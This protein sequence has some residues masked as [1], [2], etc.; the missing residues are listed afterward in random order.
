[1]KTTAASLIE[2]AASGGASGIG[3]AGGMSNIMK[4]F[5]LGG[6]ASSSVDNE[7]LILESNKVFTSMVDNLGLNTIYIE[8]DGIS[9][10][11]LYKDSPIIVEVPDSFFYRLKK[12]IQLK[13][14]LKDGKADI[15]LCSGFMGMKT[16]SEQNDVQLPAKIDYAEGDIYIMKSPS[17]SAN[18]NRNITVKLST[19][20]STVTALNKLVSIDF[21]DKLAD[22]IQIEIKYPNRELGEQ[23]VNT[24]MAEYN[25][26][27]RERRMTTS[28]EESAFLEKRI[29][30]LLPE[31]VASE[32]DVAE[33]GKNNK[34][35]GIEEEAK[36]I[37]SSAVSGK[38][39]KVKQE[40]EVSYYNEVLDK[41]NKSDRQLIP[42]IEG[43]GNPMIKDY[44]EL[45][46][47]RNDLATS[48][49]P[50]NPRIAK[51]DNA[52]DLMRLSII[53]NVNAALDTIRM[54]GKVANRLL[55]NAEKTRDKIPAIQMEY[56]KLMRDAKFKN[57][58]Y[59]FLVQKRENALL[60]AAS[61]DALGFIIDPA[62]TDEKPD[63]T[64]LFIV[65]IACLALSIICPT[66]VVVCMFFG[67]NHYVD[68]L[69]DLN[70]D[71][72]EK[73]A[74]EYSGHDWQVS[75]LRN[76]I[77][78]EPARKLVLIGN[79]G[80]GADMRALVGELSNSFEKIGINC[81]MHEA[82]VEGRPAVTNDDLLS[83]DFKAKIESE[84]K[85]NK[86]VLVSIPDVEKFS[87]LSPQL[88]ADYTQMLFVVPVPKCVHRK[89]L[90]AI[91]KSV[92]TTT[93]V[94]TCLYR[95]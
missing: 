83:S 61:T 10:K 36:L 17:Y 45:I 39:N 67:R 44:N 28:R 12:N 6:F 16:L 64:K 5:S 46:L 71:N 70:F 25:N 81:V 14:K 21:C 85:A 13:I 30:E 11:Q 27:R 94:V 40:F 38:T 92:V 43:L 89:S 86:Y 56:A 91:L 95:I 31:L 47:E 84:I 2:D 1:Y 50:G 66:V 60:N 82:K 53:D 62:H 35:V 4:T 15:K 93:R 20:A 7:I 79:Y 57:E 8:K 48:A 24:L 52:L 63:L 68:G 65:L 88:K 77:T 73:D 69:M 3:G 29:N 87:I 23:I 9:R 49:K 33:F 72:L 42:V 26:T 76:K 58:L 32:Q 59:G 90:K 80:D 34:I 41:L 75:M 55:D 22:A 37:V 19:M 78:E 18:E 54:S 51:L 74:V